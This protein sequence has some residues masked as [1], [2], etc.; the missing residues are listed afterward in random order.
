VHGHIV[1][2][3]GRAR[4]G[5]DDRRIMAPAGVLG[6]GDIPTAEVARY[7]AAAAR[8]A[9]IAGGLRSVCSTVQ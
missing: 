8:T 2:A 1:G 9:S 7:A 3:R 4:H 5:A 6:D